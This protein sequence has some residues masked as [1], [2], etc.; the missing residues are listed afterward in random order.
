MTWSLKTSAKARYLAFVATIAI[1]SVLSCV[2]RPATQPVDSI[3]P[4]RAIW[5]AASISSYEFQLVPAGAAPTSPPLH[6]VVKN[7][8]VSSTSIPCPPGASDHECDDVAR[9]WSG[10]GETSGFATNGK[11]IP[12]IFDEVSQEQLGA[13]NGRVQ[14]QIAFDPTYGFPSRFYVDDPQEFDE[15]YGFRISQFKILE[16]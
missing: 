2:K 8:Q 15:E 5:N 7:G 14:V 9:R 6:I 11:T 4:H 10:R 12:Q 16:N 13:K 1:T 3:E